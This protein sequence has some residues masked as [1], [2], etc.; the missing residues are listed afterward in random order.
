VDTTKDPKNCGA[1][2]VVCGA[3][4]ACLAGVCKDQCGALTLAGAQAYCNSLG[5]PGWHVQ[6]TNDPEGYLICTTAGVVE[7]QDCNACDT[8][9]VVVYKNN[10]HSFSC[11]NPTTMQAGKVYGGHNPCACGDNHINCGITWGQCDRLT[12][13]GVKQNLPVAQL[14]GWSLC[15][16]DKYNN[17]ATTWASIL[18][19][20]NKANILVGC[21][22]VGSA[23][24]TLAAHAPRTDVFF[25]NGGADGCGGPMT[26]I[27]AP[28][29]A[30]GVGWYYNTTWSFGFTP[31]GETL[32][33]C[34]CDFQGANPTNRMCWHSQGGNINSGYR[35]GDNDLNGN[36]NWER[37]IYQAP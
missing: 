16:S 10:P 14:A 21:R 37:L 26:P 31:Q 13:S 1:C 35:C 12:F 32:N 9:R 20:C 22:P 34:S 29:N 17:S 15:Y 5:G 33:R 19:Q 27:N 3:G 2:G 23:N 7:G 30:N 6:Y 24:L 4:Q 28:H 11:G 36:P 8:Y 25:N 18:G